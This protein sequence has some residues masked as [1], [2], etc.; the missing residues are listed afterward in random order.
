MTAPVFIGDE[1][2][3]SG[4][5]LAGMRIRVPQDDDLLTTLQWACEQAP[6]VLI[7]ANIAQ[8]LPAA[9][10]DKFLAQV[11]PPV[12]IVPDV[13]SEAKLPDIAYRLRQQLGMLE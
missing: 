11:S 8:Q 7:S 1:V 3:A 9:E 13:R 6:L 12:V 4:F 10:L 2:S 5:R